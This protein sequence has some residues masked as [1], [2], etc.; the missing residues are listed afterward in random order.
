[1]NGA[2]GTVQPPPGGVYYDS[3]KLKQQATELLAVQGEFPANL[4]RKTMS[5]ESNFRGN[6]S[7]SAQQPPIARKRRGKFT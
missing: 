1:M 6:P 3:I 2:S 5:S 7:G 4:Q